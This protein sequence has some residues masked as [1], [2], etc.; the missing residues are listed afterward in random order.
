MVLFKGNLNYIH[1]QYIHFQYNTFS[2]QFL[3]FR[4][5]LTFVIIANLKALNTLVLFQRRWI[6]M[7]YSFWSFCA[8][9]QF[10]G[11][12]KWGPSM[13]KAGEYTKEKRKKELKESKKE[14]QQLLLLL[15]CTIWKKTFFI[16]IT[17]WNK[18]I[19]RKSSFLPNALHLLASK[20]C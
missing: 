11:G 7:T 16:V 9:V 4:Y 12:K 15:Y 14:K 10:L 13:G 17:F 20:A 8:S 1:F 19:W 5:L 6:Y 18:V 2:I 3:Y